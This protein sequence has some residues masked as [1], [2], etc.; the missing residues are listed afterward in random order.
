MYGMKEQARHITTEL[1]HHSYQPPQAFAAP[2]PAVHKASTV[3]FDSVQD[4]RTR[5]W[6]DKSGYTY[7]LHGTPT[8]YQLEG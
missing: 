6:L 3:I 1:V 5:R 4:M 8:T 2:Q 7:G